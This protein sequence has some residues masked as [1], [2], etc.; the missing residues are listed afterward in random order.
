VV[1]SSVADPRGT[2]SGNGFP[3]VRTEVL[4]AQEA[5]FANSGLNCM[6]AFAFSPTERCCE[7]P[8]ILRQGYDLTVYLRYLANQLP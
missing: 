4:E 7:P 8:A 1:L 3:V 5:L 6:S 2:S